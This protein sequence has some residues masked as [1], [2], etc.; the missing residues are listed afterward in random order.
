MSQSLFAR[1]NTRICPL[2]RLLRLLRFGSFGGFFAITPYHNHAQETADHR[3]T[4]QKEDDRDANGPDAG[5][6]EGL[7]GVLLV[8]EG[9]VAGGLAR[10]FDT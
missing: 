5:R 10:W 2:L 8:D 3:A 6:E 1:S 9:L 7:E 4:K